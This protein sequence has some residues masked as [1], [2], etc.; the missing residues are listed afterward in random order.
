MCKQLLGLILLLIFAVGAEGQ[1]KAITDSSATTASKAEARDQVLALL[2]EAAREMRELRPS[3]YRIRWQTQMAGLLWRHD[4]KQARVLFDNAAAD[5][6]ALFDK[7]PETVD[8][9]AGNGP[10]YS[11]HL[12][13]RQELVRA[14]AQFDGVAALRFVRAT[15]PLL[16]QY[17]TDDNILEQENSLLTEIATQIAAKDPK[18]ALKLARESLDK[19][20]QGQQINLLQKLKE[21]HRPS[22]NEFAQ[23]LYEK[24]KQADVLKNNTTSQV[25]FGFLQY[26]HEA[27]GS[28]GAPLNERELRSYIAQLIKAALSVSPG[29]FTPNGYS[30]EFYNAN[31]ICNFFSNW[32]ELEKYAPGRGA[33]LKA[34]AEAWQRAFTG[35]NPWQNYYEVIQNKTTPEALEKL[36]AAP[37]EMRDNLYTQLAHKLA[38]EGNYEQARQIV[39]DNLKNAG[40]RDNTLRG[41]EQLQLNQS[42]SK[43]DIAAARAGLTRLRSRQERFQALLQIA[44]QLKST[45]KKADARVFLD[46]ARQLLPSRPANQSQLYLY[47]ALAQA[48]ASDDNKK[49]FELLES[50]LDQFN[51]LCVA[52]E[53]VDGFLGQTY[54][55]GEFQPNGS[56]GEFAQ[57]ISFTLAALVSKDMARARKCLARLQRP[58]VRITASLAIAENL[59]AAN[60][61]GKQ[62]SSVPN[63]VDGIRRARE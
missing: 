21:L 63:L 7:L 39:N 47:F 54:D 10:D 26:A 24:L 56:L 61:D 12:Q 55:N 34:R 18:E 6:R 46:E 33:E 49:S 43:G 8:E 40:S 14:W 20:I 44:E 57:Q 13:L 37:P 52:A 25:A 17:L 23:Q 4:E 30:Q 11:S 27:L 22:A 3:D 36:A 62:V 29:K 45:D 1:P 60:E 9:E 2:G 35:N 51:E 53:R 5:W 28:E 31:N 58:E 59:L 48:Y 19:G 50:L 42:I 41:L 32:G 38:G 16:E 15:R